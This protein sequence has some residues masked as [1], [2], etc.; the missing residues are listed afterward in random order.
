MALL[1][2]DILRR[3]KKK[4]WGLHGKGLPSKVGLELSHTT[5]EP[6]VVTLRACVVSG[7]KQ[8]LVN[9]ATDLLKSL[10]K[11]I[12]YVIKNSLEDSTYLF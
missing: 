8:D 3:R 6:S 12:P 11:E 2:V 9:G 1:E 5:A 10:E 4:W 7:M